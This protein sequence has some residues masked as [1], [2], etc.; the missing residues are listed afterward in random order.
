[1]GSL[2]KGLRAAILHLG[3]D[4]RQIDNI[5][6]L[7]AQTTSW[8]LSCVELHLAPLPTGHGIRG[9]RPSPPLTDRG[10]EESQDVLEVRHAA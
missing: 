8:D 2:R 9:D 3:C 7:V 6:T 4:P 10:A 1:M 5:S